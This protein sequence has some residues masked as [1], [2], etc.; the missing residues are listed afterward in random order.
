MQDVTHF[1]RDMCGVYLLYQD[2]EVAYIG[3]SIHVPS[4]V[5]IHAKEGKIKFNRVM[6]TYCAMDELDS[7]EH[8]L[9]QEHWPAGNKASKHYPARHYYNPAKTRV[10]LSALGLKPKS[11]A[12]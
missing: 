11:K 2:E 7:L 6:V 12:V 9:I 8:K 10:D 5:R 4:R 3:A 1:A